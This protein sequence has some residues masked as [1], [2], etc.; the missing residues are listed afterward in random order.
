[1]FEYIKEKMIEGGYHDAFDELER[2]RLVIDMHGIAVA[3][4][5]EIEQKDR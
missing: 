3:K 2:G 4:E 5:T 1:M